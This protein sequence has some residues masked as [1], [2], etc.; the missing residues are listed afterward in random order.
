MVA[1]PAAGEAPPAGLSFDKPPPLIDKPPPLI[2]KPPPL[3]DKPPPLIDKPI[4][5]QH[6][7]HQI[8]WR[9]GSRPTLGIQRVSSRRIP[10]VAPELDASRPLVHL[11]LKIVS[12]THRDT[13]FRFSPGEIRTFGR[14]A[15]WDT[16]LDFDPLLSARHFQV[17]AVS[18]HL[19]VTD[20]SSTNGTFVNDKSIDRAQVFIG[21]VVRAGDTFFPGRILSATSHG[22]GKRGRATGDSS[23]SRRPT[24]FTKHPRGARSRT[25]G[26]SLIDS[27]HAANELRLDSDVPRFEAT[28]EQ[29]A[30]PAGSEV[31]L[32]DAGGRQI[33]SP[34]TPEPSVE[35]AAPEP[36]V[37]PATP[38]PSVEPATP[39]S[40]GEPIAPES[41][42]LPVAPRP[43]V[44]P[45]TPPLPALDVDCT[46]SICQTGLL[47]WQAGIL[48]VTPVD[49]AQQLLATYSCYFLVDLQRLNSPILSEI[50]Q[51]TYLMPPP[52]SHL[53][54]LSAE[55]G[56]P[57]DRVIENAWNQDSLVC[58][59][60]MLT[61]GDLFAY[62]RALLERK[63]EGPPIVNSGA[64]LFRGYL[65]NGDRQSVERFF[66]QIKAVLIESEQPD[67]WAMYTTHAEK[68]HVKDLGLRPSGDPTPSLRPHL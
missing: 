46:L 43:P 55:D 3:I 64:N 31:N 25:S 23:R 20:F 44:L 15:P 61:P 60:S 34:G 19:I 54:V 57:L 67:R 14:T 22:G 18:D 1:V 28:Q 48:D 16:S 42:V 12:D 52:D 45:T 35:S 37:E 68:Q 38:E 9:D 11:Q 32:P 2:D 39:E 5:D 6:L 40:P 21:D 27:L 36:P 62:L 47:C 13:E 56:I 50:Q 4:A 63:Q 24:R 7:P 33:Q 10:A 41:S 29:P 17:E 66:S 49:V 53:I 51:P 58:L 65:E 30:K 59:F 8:R 26:P